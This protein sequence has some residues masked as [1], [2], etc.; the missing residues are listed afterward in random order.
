MKSPEGGKADYWKALE[1]GL[2]DGGWYTGTERGL[3][4]DQIWCTP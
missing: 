2:I 3:E 1:R 4:Q